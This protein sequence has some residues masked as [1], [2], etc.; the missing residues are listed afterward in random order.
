MGP[1]RPERGQASA[2]EAADRLDGQMS[3]RDACRPSAADPR[4]PS[5]ADSGSGS[6]PEAGS[7]EHG[8]LEAVVNG[9]DLAAATAHFRLCTPCQHEFV[10]RGGLLPRLGNRSARRPCGDPAS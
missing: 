2:I 5:A 9:S 4:C 3:S 8:G 6:G 1:D 7:C 10:D